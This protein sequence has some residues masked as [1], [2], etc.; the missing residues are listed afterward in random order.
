MRRKR[1]RVIY[2]VAGLVSKEEAG[3]AISFAREF[4]GKIS[5][6]ISGQPGLGL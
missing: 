6:I 4:V 3:Q 5:E 2:E 1:H